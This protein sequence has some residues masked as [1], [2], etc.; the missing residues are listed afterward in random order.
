MQ[1]ISFFDILVNFVK[2]IKVK[3][4]KVSYLIQIVMK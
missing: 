1:Y 2:K 4:L 3:S